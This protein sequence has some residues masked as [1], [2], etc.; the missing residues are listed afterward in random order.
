MFLYNL[1]MEAIMRTSTVLSIQKN[2]NARNVELT[3]MLYLN[4]KFCLISLISKEIMS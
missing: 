3:S 1:N 4:K 2:K